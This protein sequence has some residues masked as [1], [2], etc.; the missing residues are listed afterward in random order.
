MGYQVLARKWR[1][2]KFE[3][4]VGQEHV[5]R[6]LQNA[7]KHKRLSHAYLFTGTRGVGKTSIA[8]LFAK[9]IRCESPTEEFNPCLVCQNC[10]DIDLGNSLDF[11]EIDG[12]SN[13]SVEDVRA[14]IENV[15]YLPARGSYKVYV[16]DEVHMLSNSAFNALLKTLEEPPA[17]TIFILATT[18]PHKLLGTVVSRCQ[19]YDFKHVSFEIIQ[20][21]LEKIAA[22]ENITFGHPSITK[23]IAKLAKGSIRDSLSILDQVLGLA[24][25]K[26]VREED[27]SLALGLIADSAMKKLL[28]AILSGNVSDCSKLYLSFMQSNTDLRKFCDQVLDSIYKIISNIDSSSNDGIEE[29]IDNEMLKEFS[30]AELIWIYETFA[31][32]FNWALSSLNP[33]QV[34]SIILQKVCL[35]RDILISSQ[36]R[37]VYVNTATEKT[38]E[39]IQKKTI[40]KSWPGFIEELRKEN[41]TTASNIE[42]G[43]LVEDIF[44]NEN[45]LSITLGFLKEAEVFKEFLDK[46]EIRDKILKQLSVYFELDEKQ[47]KFFVQI[48]SQ[49]DQVEKKFKSRVEID[50]EA[51]LNEIEE[52]KKKILN[53]P[54]VREAEKI[55]N[56]KVDKIILNK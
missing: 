21:H 46:K 25:D 33:E 28:A 26:K 30:L 41:P 2:K 8:R 27:F 40:N 45:T 24:V 44:Y 37:P 51:R 52:K 10:K 43:N 36:R 18:D 5:I 29:I 31:K 12:A 16:I 14:L 54:F 13:N 38:G 35:R 7:I 3:E 15:Q 23:K 22:L 56:A 49:E 6:T 50:E 4:V 55:F 19:R 47:I 32:D 17:H 53:D 34:I 42:H 11:T 1:P 9:A 48:L 39:L 20:G